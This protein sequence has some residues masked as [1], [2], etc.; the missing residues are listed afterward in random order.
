MACTHRKT[1]PTR[2]GFTLIELL[3]VIAII[4]VLIALLLPAVQQAREAA[5]R[6]SCRNGLKQ[7]ALALHNYHDQHQAFP[8]GYLYRPGASQ[9]NASGFGWGTMVLPLLD[10]SALYHSFN[11]NLPLWDPSHAASRMV[12]L[13][14]F[15]CPSDTVSPNHYVEMGPQPEAYAMASYVSSFGPPDLDDTQEKRDGI[16]SRNSRTNIRDVTDGLTN[17]LLLGEREN[18]PF[19]R[20]GSHGVHVEY[21]TTWS[22]AV[23][24]WDDPTDDHGHMSLFQTGHVPND[25]LS[26]DRDVSAPHIGYAQ[27]ALGDG[28]VRAISESIDFGVYQALSTRA[29]SEKLSDY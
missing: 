3:V 6:A 20:A 12:R 21:E 2:A 29:G 9:E 1:S 5:R 16:F 10:Q 18:G 4:S 27:F 19:R 7:I 8:P 17:T 28:S 14:I 24:Q 15:L 23:R 13:P 26:D 25:L 22:G 11:F